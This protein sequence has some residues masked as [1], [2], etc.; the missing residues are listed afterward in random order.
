MC[1]FVVGLWQKSNGLKLNTQND[2]FS[3]QIR[4]HKRLKSQWSVNDKQNWTHWRRWKSKSNWLNRAMVMEGFLFE[5]FVKIWTCCPAMSLNY[6]RFR[7]NVI[8]RSKSI[9]LNVIFYAQQLTNMFFFLRTG[10]A[11]LFRQSGQSCIVHRRNAGLN[12]LRLHQR[13][14]WTFGRFIVIVFVKSLCKKNHKQQQYFSPFSLIFSWFQLT[15]V[16]E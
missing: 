13:R 11:R 2:A 1:N 7:L 14:L 10:Y 5:K 8:N 9:A 12:W 3:H 15:N 4:F 6:K 16:W